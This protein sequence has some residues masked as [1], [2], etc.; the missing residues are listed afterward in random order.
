MSPI[1]GVDVTKTVVG[2]IV[3]VIIS[4][5]WPEETGKD[6][7][8]AVVPERIVI[9]PEGEGEDVTKGEGPE[10]RSGPEEPMVMVVEPMSS[11]PSAPKLIM[12]EM[13]IAESIMH[14]IGS[15]LVIGS[16]LA[17][18]VRDMSEMLLVIG[19]VMTP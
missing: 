7:I 16:E 10:H 15:E 14:M 8:G 18:L 17:M 4:P 9:R 5:V 3:G 12:G 2:P 19:K 13:A 1:A 6:E 11:E